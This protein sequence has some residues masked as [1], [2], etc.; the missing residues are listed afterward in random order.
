MRQCHQRR[1]AL[2][3]GLTELRLAETRLADLRAERPPPLPPAPVWDEAAEQRYSQVDQDLDRQR[4][5][6]DLAAWQRQQADQPALLAQQRQRE[7]AAQ[8][9]LNGQ[10]Q[11]LQKRYPGL[12]TGPSSIEI[13]PQELERLSRCPSGPA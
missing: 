6:Q 5:E 1:R 9:R 4:Y 10:M 7:A 11:R 3:Q 2:L 12:F 13:R 8:Q